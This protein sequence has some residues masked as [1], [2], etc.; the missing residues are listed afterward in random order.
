MRKLFLLI[1]MMF[2]VACDIGQV[3]IERHPAMITVFDHD[4]V[5]YASQCVDWLS[6]DTEDNALVVKLMYS[7]KLKDVSLIWDE[8]RAFPISNEHVYVVQKELCK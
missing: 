1:A 4:E 8:I 5:I 6:V 3:S 7:A 2:F